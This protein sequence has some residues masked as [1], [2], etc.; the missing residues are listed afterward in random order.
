MGAA[1]RK[2]KERA[3]QKS[4]GV[5]EAI[6]AIDAKL[7]S[8]RAELAAGVVSARSLASSRS[9]LTPRSRSR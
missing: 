7:A 1:A 2:K 3:R 4:D 5:E 9:C 8:D 6:A